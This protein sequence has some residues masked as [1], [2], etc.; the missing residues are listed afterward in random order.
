MAANG[1]RPLSSRAVPLLIRNPFP[2]RDLLL[3]IGGCVV[4]GFA[5]IGA[6]AFEEMA[7]ALFIPL[8]VRFILSHA[9]N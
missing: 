7:V 6:G 1:G 3:L 4:A 2:R 5:A 8:D 9:D